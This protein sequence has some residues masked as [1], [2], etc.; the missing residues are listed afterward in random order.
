[1]GLSGGIRGGGVKPDAPRGAG[2]RHLR[3]NG[4]VAGG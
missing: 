4:I 1:M 3:R 2:Y